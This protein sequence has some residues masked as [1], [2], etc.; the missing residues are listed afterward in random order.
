MTPV[1]IIV[2]VVLAVALVAVIIRQRAGTTRSTAQNPKPGTRRV[3]FPFVASALSRPALDAALRL[4]RAEDATLVPVFLASVP[5]HLPLDAPLPRQAGVCIPLQEAIEQRA[6][7]FGVPV[8]SRLERG[9]TFRHAMRQTIANER[10]DR[11]VIAAAVNGA[12]GFGPDDVAWLLEHATGE[13]LV[14]RPGTEDQLMPSAPRTR[15]VR[16][17]NGR[18]AARGRDPVH[19]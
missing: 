14:L 12:H 8:D 4:A 15:K 10:F 9:R 11:I 16:G 1:L 3:L 13:I 18:R 6:A 5:L 2:A 7:S 17:V 19:S